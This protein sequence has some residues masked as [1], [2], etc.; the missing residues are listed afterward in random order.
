MKTQVIVAT[1]SV[2]LVN[3][4][5][6]EDIVV[7]ERQESQSVFKH[8]ARQ[9]ITDWLEEYGLGDLWEKNFLGGRP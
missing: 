1:Q 4:L 8:L 3:Q 6:P 2:T 7:V 9:D 5:S